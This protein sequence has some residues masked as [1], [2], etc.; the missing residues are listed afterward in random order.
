M[1]PFIG[2][3][4]IAS[5]RK[6]QPSIQ[7]G[8]IL[9][10][11]RADII[12]QK[13]ELTVFD[14]IHSDEAQEY[15]LHRRALAT[16][17]SPYPADEVARIESFI[18]NKITMDRAQ[19]Q[20]NIKSDPVDAPHDACNGWRSFL[21]P[22]SLD[23]EPSPERASATSSSSPHASPPPSPLTGKAVVQCPVYDGAD[24]IFVDGI[25][26]TEGAMTGR[27]LVVAESGTYDIAEHTVRRYINKA[28][29][30]GTLPTVDLGALRG[31]H[32]KLTWL[33]KI[34]KRMPLSSSLAKNLVARSEVDA[35]A[36]TFLPSHDY[37]SLKLLADPVEYSHELFMHLAPMAATQFVH[38]A[39]TTWPSDPS[40][41]GARLRATLLAASAKSPP[42]VYAVAPSSPESPAAVPVPARRRQPNF[43]GAPSTSA[44]AMPVDVSAH[45]LCA[46]LRTLADSQTT[47]DEFL[48][49]SVTTTCTEKNAASVRGNV[50][51]SSGALNRFLLGKKQ[52]AKT[53]AHIAA[54]SCNA[55]MLADLLVAIDEA[56]T[57]VKS[58]SEPSTSSSDLSLLAQLMTPADKTKEPEQREANAKL[59]S[60][61]AA[62]QGD[63]MAWAR[64]AEMKRLYDAKDYATLTQLKE[65][66]QNANVLR[67]LLAD[68]P[69][70]QSTLQGRL[71]VDKIDLIC[72][73]RRAYLVRLLHVLFPSSK[74]E[75][76]PPRVKTAVHNLMI[77]RLG[78]TKLLELIDHGH[79]P[80]K[81]EDPLAGFAALSEPRAVFNQAIM[82][83]QRIICYASPGQTCEAIGF[84]GLL[85]TTV[86][87]FLKRGATW[88]LLSAW[89]RGVIIEMES[90]RETVGAGGILYNLADSIIQ[91]RTSSFRVKFEEA[92]VEA[93]LKAL[94]DS[95]ANAKP[96]APKTPQAPKALASPPAGSSKGPATTAP[97]SAGSA[98]LSAPPGAP[99]P[100]PLARPPYS[101]QVLAAQA[102]CLA[103]VGKVDDKAPCY[104]HFV[105][106]K[107]IL[108]ASCYYH[109]IGGTAG[110]FPPQA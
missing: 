59:I 100:A 32:G 26:K 62:I 92:L 64:L 45:H 89:L 58:A 107:C 39:I 101:P 25:L 87:D 88:P 74:P 18:K 34:F 63:Q 77:G 47:Y 9:V 76:V 68:V 30:A 20:H 49:E 78:R 84:F 90:D 72:D 82:L 67:L 4:A 108:G 14:G 41:L 99:S 66:E 27:V 98:N 46:I 23:D 42:A 51:R 2:R 48:L 95:F 86:D 79:D 35:F 12:A 105:H 19:V 43:G 37:A 56:T 102:L 65:S 31:G 21:A 70:I 75:H 103:T 44:P 24:V 109:H 110:G 50:Y 40:R 54:G 33:L 10:L 55:D 57:P 7:P 1:S 73:V 71:P 38:L 6:T 22:P 29:T 83:A 94:S 97:P 104:K 80:H 15:A 11:T 81:I 69:D 28:G 13:Y 60:A 17:T 91:E 16:G 8:Q 3:V 61:A 53:L 52:D 96:P 85:V 93:R 5:G 36:V 106:G